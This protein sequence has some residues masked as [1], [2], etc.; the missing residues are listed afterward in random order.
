MGLTIALGYF[1]HGAFTFHNHYYSKWET[2]GRYGAGYKGIGLWHKLQPQRQFA[3][4]NGCNLNQR[5]VGSLRN[6][7]WQGKAKTSA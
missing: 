5:A 4:R 1:N 2:T 7:L 6:L 3:S